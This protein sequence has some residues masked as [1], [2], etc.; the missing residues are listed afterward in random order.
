MEVRQRHGKPL[1]LSDIPVHREFHS[2]EALFFT[3]SSDLLEQL[4]VSQ[5]STSPSSYAK[6]AKSTLGLLKNHL[7]SVL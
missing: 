7:N 5:A 2:G 6:N 3:K 4:K 1:L